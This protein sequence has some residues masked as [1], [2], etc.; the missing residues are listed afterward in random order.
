ME[1]VYGS[2][3]N[4]C[5]RLTKTI[6]RA[7]WHMKEIAK[8]FS[9]QQSFYSSKRFERAIIFINANVVLDMCVYQLIHSDKLD[10]TGAVLIYSAQMV[11]A[12][13]QTNKLMEEK[14][15]ENNEA[16]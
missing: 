6:N 9:N 11:Y 12:G 14:K 10:A 1:K 8:T 7:K 2:K 16:K 3:I 5:M 15:S 13:F 4:R